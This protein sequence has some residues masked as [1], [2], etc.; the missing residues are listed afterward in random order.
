MKPTKENL[1][2]K[3]FYRCALIAALSIATFSQT[4]SASAELIY[5]VATQGNTQFLLTWDSADPQNLL[6]SHAIVSGPSPP[7]VLGIDIRPST[8]QLYALVAQ[9]GFN[10]IANTPSIEYTV[11]VLD[12]S[13]TFFSLPRTGVVVS[14]FS[15]G[16]DFNPMIDRIRIV[17]D[18]NK[19]YV[20]N[21]NTGALQL[22]ATDL[23]YAVGDPNFGTD[24]N[25]GGSAYTNN[26]AVPPASTQLYG[27]DTG[28]DILVTQAN[29]AGTLGTVG[30]LGLDVSALG[31]FDISATTGIAYATMTPAGSSQSSLYTINLTTGAA[32]PVGVIGGGLVIT[33]M[34][35]ATI[36]EPT[37]A[38]GA[39]AVLAALVGVRRRQN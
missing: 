19:N 36:P 23:A 15:H 24:P 34:A 25:V 28:L 31:G 7:T 10:L 9:Y 3:S 21:P 11:G 5:G 39:L 14:G 8:N 37:T 17:N 16:F 29:N 6:A 27:I 18:V 2:M 4:K 12:P 35:V 1:S 30:P 22:A 26:S 20:I 13:G 38:A 33:A 32:T